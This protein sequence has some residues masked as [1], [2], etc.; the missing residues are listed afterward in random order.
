MRKKIRRSGASGAAV[1]RLG[2]RKTLPKKRQ[3]ENMQI[4]KAVPKLPS[5]GYPFR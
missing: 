2:K 4:R 5:A 3:C 1:L